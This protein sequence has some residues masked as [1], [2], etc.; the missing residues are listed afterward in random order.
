MSDARILFDK[1]PDRE[2]FREY[3]DA[4]EHCCIECRRLREYHS[5][6]MIDRCEAHFEYALQE[7]G[8]TGSYAQRFDEQKIGQR[9]CKFFDQIP[10]SPDALAAMIRHKRRMCEMRMEGMKRLTGD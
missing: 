3:P 5:S 9:R 8:T 4:E 2:V 7:H 1:E 6:R 10:F